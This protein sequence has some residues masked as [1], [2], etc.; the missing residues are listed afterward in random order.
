MMSFKLTQIFKSN[1][2]LCHFVLL[3]KVR[4]AKEVVEDNISQGSENKSDSNGPSSTPG[5]DSDHDYTLIGGSSPTHT[6]DRL[7][8]SF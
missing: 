3:F 2:I 6:E 4:K 7:V 1:S 5:L 8:L